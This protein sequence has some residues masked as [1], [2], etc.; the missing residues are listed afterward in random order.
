MD[1]NLSIIFVIILVLLSAFFV[2]AEFAIVRVRPSRVKQLIK[3]GNKTAKL[4]QKILNQID[5]YLSACQLGITLASLGLGALGEPAVSYFLDP[6]LNSLNLPEQVSHIISMTLSFSI[7]SF[8]SV[9]LGELV[10]KNIAIY[11]AE[12]LSLILA[13][14]LYLF[15]KLA[16]PII[17]LM[18]STANLIIRLFGINIKEDS[19][20]SHSAEELKLLLSDSYKKGTLTKSTY[21]LMENAFK[22]NEKVSRE[23]M[24]PRTD[25]VC[26]D[27]T[28]PIEKIIE[29]LKE[30][31]TYTRF[32]I[33]EGDKDHIIGILNT[34]RLFLEKIDEN[35]NLLDY[36]QKA[37]SILD[38]TPIPL[39]FKKMKKEKIQM[40]ILNDEYGGTEGLVTMED[41]MEELFGDI[42]DEFDDDEEPLIQ[43][44][45]DNTY[46]LEGITTLHDIHYTCKLDV[47]HDEVE[48]IGGFINTIS[49]EV[50]TNMEITYDNLVFKILEID[51]SRIEK[52]KMTILEKNESEDLDSGE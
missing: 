14:P 36:S 34:K 16:Q 32:P 24:T 6:I 46:I 41:I 47:K 22:F 3:E 5:V 7:I 51:N 40:I 4:V 33:I 30:N 8:I 31:D 2:A 10:P 21:E 19:N 26:V 49:P 28:D 43:K 1:D 27:I 20:N 42:H 45:D 18:N 48:T 23:I 29:I 11:K 50:R 35:T 38:S 25:M 44:I 52:V 9:V 15:Y 12:K 37:Y 39:T 17:V 13:R